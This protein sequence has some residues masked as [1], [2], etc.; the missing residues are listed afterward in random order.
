MTAQ[1][2]GSLVIILIVFLFYKVGSG[3]LE[4]DNMLSKF[5]PIGSSLLAVFFISL[6]FMG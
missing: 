5:F 3:F 1:I 6:I 2:I 4:D